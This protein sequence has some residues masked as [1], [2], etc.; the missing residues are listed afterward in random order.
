VTRWG[1]ACVALDFR[2]R[3]CGRR[4]VC[5]FPI[6]FTW[7]PVR[8]VGTGAPSA[9]FCRMHE[10]WGLKG[11]DR[12]AVVGGWL[13]DAWNPEAKVWTVLTTIYETKDGLAA[14]LHWWALRRPTIFGVCEDVVYDDA[15]QP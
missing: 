4:S 12:M 6:T 15:I 7:D 5:E 3:R 11:P 9:T 13:G 2:G 8:G 1:H 14:S 10:P